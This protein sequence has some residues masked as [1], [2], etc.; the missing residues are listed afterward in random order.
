M[1]F[2]TTGAVNSANNAA[3]AIE[4]MASRIR[5][6]FESLNGMSFSFTADNQVLNGIITTVIPQIQPMAS[7][8][9]I[10][11]GDLVM[12]NENGSI[13]MMGRMENQPVVANNEQ[14]VT[15][16]TRGVAS[17]NDNVV[18]A[19]NTLIN[20]AVRIERKEMVARVS[21]SSGLGRTNSQSADMY[22][23]VTGY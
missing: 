16:I 9:Y 4:E 5:T 8:G 22:N 3:T 20:L 23:T 15:G 13:E 12:A 21:P 17:G 18:S 7:G 2:D 6:A 1:K 11:S 14:I 10:R 19:L